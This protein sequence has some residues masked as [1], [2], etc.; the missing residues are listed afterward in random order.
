MEK[1]IQDSR[2]RYHALGFLEIANPPSPETLNAYY[3]ERYYQTEQGNYRKAY[4]NEELA[5]INLKI[6]QKASLVNRFRGKNTPGTFLD[7]GCGEGFA[8]LWFSAVG[9]SV[10][11]ID[12]S[13][14]GLENMN[15]DLI[16]HVESGDLFEILNRRISKGKCY[17][18]V[19]L[20]NVLE[21]VLDPV[22]L[23][24]SLRDLIAPDGIL[25]VTV[26]NDGSTYQEFLLN[27]GNISHRFW[28]AIPD[29]LAYFNY[30]SLLRTAEATGWKCNEI[31]GDFPIDFFLLH[32][33][34]N[35]VR[36][37]ANGPFAHQ[38]RLKMDLMLG[39][40]YSHERV[41]E[42]YAGLA[43]VGLGRDLTAFLSP[44]K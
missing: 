21:H 20:N 34:S 42:F 38:A 41:N 30:E 25:V 10:E 18:L 4:S 12:Y 3:A 31:I 35:Y 27:N 23:L 36:D 37:R 32:P 17:D 39:D 7:V 1:K 43:R 24:T 44:Q 14:A 15:P 13:V 33:G 22:N 11:G 28:I 19:W 40:H 2:L 6:A 9:W 26:P 29:H 8:L 5:Y 16:S